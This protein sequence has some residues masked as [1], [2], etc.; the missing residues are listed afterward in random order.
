MI[1]HPVEKNGTKMHSRKMQAGGDA[2][3]NVGQ[4]T[5]EPKSP[6]LLVGPLDLRSGKK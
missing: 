2:L 6:P 4:G 5:R 3:G 1:L